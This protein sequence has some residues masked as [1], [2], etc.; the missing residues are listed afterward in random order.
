MQE[1][2]PLNP[3]RNT[4]DTVFNVEEIPK[5]MDIFFRSEGSFL[6]RDMTFDDLSDSERELLKS[7][8]RFSPLRPGIYQGITG[9]Q[10]SNGRGNML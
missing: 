8:Y 7:R 10:G 4:D 3:V 9:R 5:E 6:P 2:L 1:M